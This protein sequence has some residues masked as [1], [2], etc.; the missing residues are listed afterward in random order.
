MK[1]HLLVKD[2]GGGNPVANI[3]GG[4][5]G[6]YAFIWNRSL[7]AHVRTYDFAEPGTLQRFG[8][9]QLDLLNQKLP[10]AITLAVEEDEAPKVSLVAA[11]PHLLDFNEKLTHRV[12]GGKGFEE[13]YY[14]LLGEACPGEAFSRVPSGAEVANGAPESP[15][16]SPSVE[17]TLEVGIPEAIAQDPVEENPIIEGGSAQQGDGA[18]VTEPP[19]KSFETPAIPEVLQPAAPSTEPVAEP[20]TAKKTGG[21]KKKGE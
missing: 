9:E 14:E 7:N 16:P 2:L 18:P 1:L 13:A 4:T 21:R 3:A 8:R 6:H 5:S 17:N 19:I 10:W 15:V 20:K 11:V 12:A